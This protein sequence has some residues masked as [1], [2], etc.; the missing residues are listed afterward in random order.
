MGEATIESDAVRG[1]TVSAKEERH[2]SHPDAKRAVIDAL[3]LVARVVTE[4][5]G[6]WCE[7]VVHDLRDLDHSIVYITGNVTGRK[8]GG[9]MTDLGLAKLRAEDTEP[10]IN[11]TGYTNDGKTLK[12]SSIWFHDDAG[13]PYACMCLNLNVTPVLLFTHFANHLANVAQAPVIT[14]SFTQDVTQTIEAIISQAAHDAGKPLSVMNKED[15]LTMVAALDQKGLFQLR[16]SLPMVAKRLGVSRKTIYNYLAE[17][18]SE[19]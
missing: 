5:V 10:Q 4:T 18:Q 15:R 2:D 6:D 16:N 14:E 13:K 9:N 8:V 3:G 19:G 11:Y 1:V 17:L 12:C 7:V